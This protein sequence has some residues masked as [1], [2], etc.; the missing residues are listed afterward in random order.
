MPQ[1]DGFEF[2]AQIKQRPDGNTISLIL[3]SQQRT[4]QDRVRG[5]ELGIEEYLT[6]PIYI[7]D[8]ASRV[9]MVLKGAE[10]ERVQSTH[11]E[12]EKL[13]SQLSDIG[14]VDLVQTI[15]RTEGSGIAYVFNRHGH[16]GVIYF[17]TGR[18]V[19]AE[20][21]RLSGSDAVYRLFAWTD[22]FFEMEFK[23]IRRKDVIN[24]EPQLLFM[25]GM[26]RL[27][28]WNE[29]LKTLASLDTVCDVDYK[30]LAERL[31]EVPDEV[32]GVLRLFD[33][34]RSLTQV[35]EDCDFPDLEA[36][37]I[38][39]KL[40]GDRL[41]K[42]LRSRRTTDVSLPVGIEAWLGQEAT[43]SAA[44]T[45]SA[46]AR[47]SIDT[48]AGEET[49][50][51]QRKATPAS[52]H[53]RVTARGSA[54]FFASEEEASAF[55][56]EASE[57]EQT[58]APAAPRPLMV[59]EQFF[60]DEG[61]DIRTS[62]I[63]HTN[64]LKRSNAPSQDAK[65]ENTK[66][67]D[68][69]PQDMELRQTHRGHAAV[70][71]AAK[72]AP[73]PPPA[74]V[75]P[76]SFFAKE[77]PEEDT[78]PAHEA[79]SEPAPRTAEARHRELRG[80]H[81]VSGVLSVDPPPKVSSEL[82]KTILGRAAKPVPKAQDEALSQAA[83][84]PVS[85]SAFSGQPYAP[86]AAYPEVSVD[87]GQYALAS[88]PTKKTLFLGLGAVAVAAVVVIGILVSNKDSTSAPPVAAVT[89]PETSLPVAAVTEPEISPASPPAALSAETAIP[90]EPQE[91]LVVALRPKALPAA[92][93]PPRKPPVADVP[94]TVATKTVAAKEGPAEL[95]AAC[96]K[97]YRK[98]QGTYA[99]IMGACERAVEANPKSAM[100]M[101]MMANAE[102]D[103]GQASAARDWAKKA[104]QIDPNLAAPYVFV[105]GAAQLLGDK[106]EAKTAYQRYLQLAPRGKYAEDLKIIL[107]TL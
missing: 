89:E 69:K 36:L 23:P 27:E 1:M 79:A 34:R 84:E 68:T 77:E 19:D 102:L 11:K 26:R 100:A 45:E 92:P 47:H 14:V 57:P 50:A 61:D 99:A 58:L 80:G 49:V 13:T 51:E 65:P 87:T 78:L 48:G 103:R 53:D 85:P 104:L 18:V 90:P 43:A 62:G 96:V 72:A 7:N 54:G 8:I 5:L 12:G 56:E 40:Y 76:A 91:P 22:G 39:N 24:L 28:Q 64:E 52:S 97:A 29:M 98:G 31:G 86:P 10:R 75:E 33:G 37:T 6:K 3:I 42:Q 94:R 101:V 35:I 67:E 55:E 41:I 73:A 105:G 107:D 60:V 16:R 66:P 74:A 82:N 95:Y 44:A 9:G 4:M 88:A 83:P 20:A 15:E 46:P 63:W 2:C 70:Q 17:R 81:S 21:G 32:N 59:S 25:E 93:T 71:E 106:Q 38:I 30:L